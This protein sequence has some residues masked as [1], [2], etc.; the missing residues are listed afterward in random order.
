MNPADTS[1]I[2]AQRYL[3]LLRSQIWDNL[4]GASDSYVREQLFTTLQ[5]VKDAV[6]IARESLA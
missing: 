2:A 3:G 5:D 6:R 1:L 4:P